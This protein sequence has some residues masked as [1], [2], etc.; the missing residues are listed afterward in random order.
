M[1]VNIMIG[2]NKKAM[3]PK[4]NLK[5]PERSIRLMQERENQLKYD[6]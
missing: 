3:K 4:Q 6:E 2:G 5:N 1:D